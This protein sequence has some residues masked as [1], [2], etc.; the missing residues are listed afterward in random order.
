MVNQ[1]TSSKNCINPKHFRYTS[2]GIVVI[3]LMGMVVLVMVKVLG[4]GNLVV[5]VAEVGVVVLA[6]HIN[7]PIVVLGAHS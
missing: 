1:I 4:V 5:M 7:V 6:S 2:Q 3:A